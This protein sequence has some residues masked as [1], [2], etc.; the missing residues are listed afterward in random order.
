VLSSG[1]RKLVGLFIG[2]GPIAI[3]AV[4]VIAVVVAS[5]AK[6]NAQ[7]ALQS[8]GQ[9]T[10]SQGTGNGSGS[11]GSGG[12][13]G[14]QVTKA[15]GFSRTQGGFRKLATAMESY[16]KAE[17]SCGTDLSCLSKGALSAQK[18]FAAEADAQR[19]MLMPTAESRALNAKFISALHRGHDFF[20]SLSSATDL[21]KLLDLTTK[22]PLTSYTS[23][24]SKTYGKLIVALEP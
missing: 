22:F 14:T 8:L 23:N 19:S 2:L 15:E 6:H 5:G 9:P 24:L 21:T 18:A 4:A 20:H 11:N 10:A 12:T 1:A 16:A 7:N 3:A 17:G 13:G